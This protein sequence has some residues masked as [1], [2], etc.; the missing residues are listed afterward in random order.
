M[1]ILSILSLILVLTSCAFH[2]GTLTSN[3][4]DEP[5]VHKDIAVGVSSAN[6]VFHIGG[7]SKDALIA[8]ARKNMVRSR[9]LE[10]AEQ[11]NNVSVNIK[12][13]FYIIGHKTKV[14]VQADVIQPKD[15]VNQPSYSEKYL[16]KIANP[17]PEIDLFAV[18]DSV[19]V[20]N[21]NYQSGQVVRFT[22][23]DLDWIEIS[24]TDSNNIQR[25]KKYP[26]NKVYVSKPEH[27]GVTRFSRTPD[28]I[29]VGFG[30]KK[31]LVKMSGGYTTM[32]YPKGE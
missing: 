21:Y 11:Y 3:V 18:G 27:R 8:E 7:L 30:I 2:S 14:T 15:S 12:N 24:Y 22:G 28:G 9:P 19:I 6:R 23:E 32:S 25:T 26:A 13:T 20:F 17:E 4:T 31:V 10:G 29:V 1:K 16:K 5:V